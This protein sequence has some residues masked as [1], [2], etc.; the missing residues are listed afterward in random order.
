MTTEAFN[1]IMSNDNLNMVE[2]LEDAYVSMYFYLLA[3]W[4]IDDPTSDIGL[5]EEF[6]DEALQVIANIVGK[7]IYR[8]YNDG[9]GRC[10]LF[11]KDAIKST[12]DCE[13]IEEFK[14]E[15]CFGD[16]ELNTY[17]PIKVEEEAA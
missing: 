14:N 1:M 12:F 15:Y 3:A 2:K 7:D 11:V 6:T 17:E 5:R 16:N 8:F 13:T 10:Y 9:K 4:L